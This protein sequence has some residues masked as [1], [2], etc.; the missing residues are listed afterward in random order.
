M[1]DFLGATASWVCPFAE[2]AV[3]STHTCC[4]ERTFQPRIAGSLPGRAPPK[5][6]ALLGT[7]EINYATKHARCTFTGLNQTV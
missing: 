1:Q 3:P 6:E 2:Q 4:N 7:M 5:T